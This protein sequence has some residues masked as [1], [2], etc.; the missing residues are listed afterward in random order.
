MY[1]LIMV[2]VSGDSDMDQKLGLNHVGKICVKT[3]CMLTE[4]LNNRPKV[5][6]VTSL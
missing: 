3:T 6:E 4:Y 2:I 1:K 5:C